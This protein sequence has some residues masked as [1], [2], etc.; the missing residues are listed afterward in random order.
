MWTLLLFP[1]NSPF[2]MHSFRF[3]E[4][5]FFPVSWL[6]H[7]VRKIFDKLLQREALV[8]RFQRFL[9]G[10]WDGI[11]NLERGF[12]GKKE[13]LA[14]F[15]IRAIPVF[16]I[17]L[18]SVFA[19]LIRIPFRPFILPTFWSAISR[20]LFLGCLSWWIGST[21]E[22]VAIQLDSA[23]TIISILMLLGI[24]GI[25][26]TSFTNSEGHIDLG[27]I[28]MNDWFNKSREILSFIYLFIERYK[29]YRGSIFRL[30]PDL[31]VFHLYF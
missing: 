13:V 18:V 7:W 15:L 30:I 5:L 8:A 19:A 6:R 14:L 11:T 10:D 9:D 24:M 27:K 3:Y 2:R 29:R 21:Y 16:P 17:S 20:C 12:K 28:V 25:G 26:G 23:E 31:T 1:L 4:L 22:K